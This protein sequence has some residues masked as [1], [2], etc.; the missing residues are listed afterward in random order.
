MESQ[1]ANVDD[2]PHE[3][4]YRIIIVDQCKELNPDE[5]EY[6]EEELL[7]N[8]EKYVAD[9]KSGKIKEYELEEGDSQK[10]DETQEGDSQKAAASQEGDSQQ[11]GA[12]QEG[13]SK[14]IDVQEAQEDLAKLMTGKSGLLYQLT[15]LLTKMQTM[16]ATL[17]QTQSEY[18]SS[19]K[20]TKQEAGEM[21]KQ[22]QRTKEI[23]EKERIKATKLAE[24][25]ELYAGV[26]T[27]SDAQKEAV[28]G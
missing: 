3:G 10:G 18:R 20:K 4:F 11:A 21:A 12:T 28:K 22:A 9:V 16:A 23:A 6:C 17:T 15:D 13:D 1:G 19:A 7:P 25:A 27:A 26:A 2:Y 24:L 8:L 14:A 5:K